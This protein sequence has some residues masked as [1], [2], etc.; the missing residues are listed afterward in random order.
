MFK[1]RKRIRLITLVIAIIVKPF[2]YKAPRGQVYVPRDTPV[3][4][5]VAAGIALV[6]PDHVDIFK[7]E[8]RAINTVEPGQN[9]NT[10]LS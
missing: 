4:V 2:T 8:Y 7:D 10:V 5:D 3:I 9:I 6:G 1:R